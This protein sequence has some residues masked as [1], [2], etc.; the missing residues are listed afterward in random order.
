MT[1]E[2]VQVD[3]KPGGEP[4]SINLKSNGNI[5]IAVLSTTDFDATKIDTSNLSRF[6]FGDVRLTSRVSP[7]RAKLE[8]VHGDGDLDLLL[9]FSTPNIREVGALVGDSTTA[10]LAGFTRSG[11][12]IAQCGSDSDPS[13]L[14]RPRAWPARAG[15]PWPNRSGF[16]DRR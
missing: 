3:I 11:Q 7:E 2:I 16:H 6:R 8:D 9:F 5:P 4:N 10:D 14:G 15:R 1:V 13:S 12:F